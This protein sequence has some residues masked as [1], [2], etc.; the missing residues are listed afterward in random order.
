M[1]GDENDAEVGCY[2]VSRV[3][4]WS[5]V[6]R[7]S[8]VTGDLRRLRLVVTADR[9]RVRRLVK[10]DAM[11]MGDGVVTGDAIVTGTVEHGCRS[12]HS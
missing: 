12:G 9:R 1:A 11:V 5:R 7:D 8:V 3:R 10:Q 6:T 4:Q 2:G